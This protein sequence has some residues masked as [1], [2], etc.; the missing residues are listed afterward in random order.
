VIS[1]RTKIATTA[2]LPKNALIAA[3]VV[4]RRRRDTRFSGKIDPAAAGRATVSTLSTMRND[5][6]SG[7]GFNVTI[8]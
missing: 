6:P 7:N 1:A 4:N 2:L 8:L 3:S 5:V